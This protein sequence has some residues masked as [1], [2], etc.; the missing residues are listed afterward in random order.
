M[1][2]MTNDKKAK[3]I[4]WYTHKTL[5]REHTEFQEM[6]EYTNW[7]QAAW[8]YIRIWWAFGQPKSWSK[9]LGFEIKMYH[10]KKDK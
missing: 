6:L 1:F 4:V 3:W 8:D 7:F 2:G 5:D 9:M 10:L